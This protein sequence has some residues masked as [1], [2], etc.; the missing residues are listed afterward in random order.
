MFRLIHLLSLTIVLS[1][2]SCSSDSRQAEYYSDGNLK[3][4]KYYTGKKRDGNW[5]FLKQNG[6]T[7][8]TIL[9]DLDDTI[10]LC[11]FSNGKLSALTDFKNNFKKI[12][13]E[14]S[15]KTVQ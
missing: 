6:D 4:I 3:S 10:R 14:I 7:T 2:C 12:K 9:F 1:I 13:S 5:L 11:N 15:S 8:K